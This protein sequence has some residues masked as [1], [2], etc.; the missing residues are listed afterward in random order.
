MFIINYNIGIYYLLSKNQKQ[1]DAFNFNFQLLIVIV[2]VN[3]NKVSML[4]TI[5]THEF[6]IFY[7]NC[8][9]FMILYL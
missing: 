3:T 7:M 8:I 4:S 9:T 2:T 6:R 5:L 1:L